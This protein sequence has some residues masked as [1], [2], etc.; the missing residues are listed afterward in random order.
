MSGPKLTEAQ[1]QRS[2]THAAKGLGFRVYHAAY[3][4]GSERGFPDLVICGH[5]RVFFWE[6]KGPKPKVY[7]EQ[8]AWIAELQ[9]AGMNARI[10]YPEDYDDALAELQRAYQEALAA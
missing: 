9:A 10:L 2:L 1:M 3:A 4:I 5:G 7:P 6:L 8:E